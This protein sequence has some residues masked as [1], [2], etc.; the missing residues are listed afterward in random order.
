[1]KGGSIVNINLHHISFI[2]LPSSISIQVDTLNV[3][4]NVVT[5]Y[6]PVHRMFNK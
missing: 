2:V 6:W 4:K 1:M 3:Y 5:N